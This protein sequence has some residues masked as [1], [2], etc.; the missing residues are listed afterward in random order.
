MM[1]P[2]KRPGGVQVRFAVRDAASGALGAA[3]EFVDIPEMEKGTLALSGVVLG[4]ESQSALTPDEDMAA[5]A[6]LSS[7][8]LRVFNPG[9]RL[10]YTY[11]IYNAA[12]PVDTRV[13]VWRNGRPF[14][15]APP[16][17]LAAAPKARPLKAAGGIK[18]GERMPPGD[19]VFQVS[20]ITRPA[21]GAKPKTAT[22]WTSFEIRGTP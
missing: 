14:F 22:R 3:A 11:E 19:Y 7:P 12:V 16:S 18:L 17:T 5:V 2:V 9:A 6:R 4:E 8:A 15:S 20:A 10:V 1:V 21:G 13:T